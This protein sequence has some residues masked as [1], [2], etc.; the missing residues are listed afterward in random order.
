[1]NFQRLD[2]YRR[3]A[4]AAVLCYPLKGVWTAK[5]AHLSENA[6]FFLTEEGK[7]KPDKVMRVAR[8]GYHSRKELE[9]EV[10]WI[11]HL[12]SKGTVKLASLVPNSRGERLTQVKTEEQTYLCMIFQYLDGAPLNP[13][14]DPDAL[15]DF[16]QIG[17]IAACLHRDTGEWEESRRLIRP[18][19]DYESMVGIHGL[20][21]NWRQCLQLEPEDHR[22][23]ERVCCRIRED[24]EDYG[25]SR[26]HYGLIHAD[27][28]ASNLLKKGKDIWVIDFDDCGFG[29]HLYDAAASISFVEEDP[30]AGQWIR[31]WLDGYQTLI[32]LKEEDMRRIPTF[33]MARRIQ[34]LA[35]ITSHRDSDPA[36][37]FYESFA[38][39]TAKLA[40]RYE[41]GCLLL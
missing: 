22:L 33:V 24:L 27:L 35:W 34:L 31:A 17:R 7:G 15:E 18:C 30:R 5:L 40:G 4:A 14:E 39:G 26:E 2:D 3:A 21:G 9:A 10:S 28:R 1:M 25:C 32:P 13:K 16:R 8:A 12:K 19:W 41:K 38:Q 6:T 36:G 20:F 23:L 11:M 29:W 37:L